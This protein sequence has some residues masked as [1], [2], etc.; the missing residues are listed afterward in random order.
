MIEADADHPDAIREKLRG[1]MRGTVGVWSFRVQLCRDLEKQPVEDPTVPWK[2]EEA[3]WVQ[4]AT[5]HA[6]P[7][8]S[9]SPEQVRAVDEGM[10]FSI[11]T[12]LEAH[13][14][15]GN[16]NRARNETYRRSAAFR[17][18]FNGCPIHE[19][20]TQVTAR[21]RTRKAP[22]ARTSPSVPT[23]AP[24]ADGD[25]RGRSRKCSTARGCSSR[26]RGAVAAEQAGGL[27][28][29]LLRLGQARR[30]SPGGILRKWR[31]GDGLGDHHGALRAG[32]LRAAH[33][34]GTRILVGS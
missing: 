12:G 11:W 13:R 8:D 1:D 24:L 32:I 6:E 14:P 28:L 18:R 4:V 23:T 21:T 9:W 27:R 17:E 29:R 20:G 30:S 3:P 10:R 33:L 15:L 26:A 31:Q 2:E 16:I 34:P 19:P 7:Q 22:Q 25:R 5:I